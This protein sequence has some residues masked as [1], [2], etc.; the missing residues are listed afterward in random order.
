M[1]EVKA[2]KQPP[3]T[4]TVRFCPVCG[5]DDFFR[6]L[7]KRHFAGGRLCGGVPVSVTYRRV[8]A[9]QVVTGEAQPSPN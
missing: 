6:S 7:G 1:N 2:V 8:A 5:H 3:E 4:V 9:E